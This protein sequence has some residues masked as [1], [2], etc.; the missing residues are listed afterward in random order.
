MNLLYKQEVQGASECCRDTYGKD[1]AYIR[2]EILIRV[3]ST[4]L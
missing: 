2:R 1:L 3:F 4:F